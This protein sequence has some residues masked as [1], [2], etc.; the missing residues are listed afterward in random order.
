MPSPPSGQSGSP[1]SDSGG[2]PGQDGSRT[3]NDGSQPGDGSKGLP[4][5]GNGGQP[6]GNSS[7]AG[8]GD[9]QQDGDDWLEGGGGGGDDEWS[10]SNENLPTGS[11]SET[12]GASSTASRGPQ[13]DEP[14]GGGLD[15]ALDEALEGF[16]GTIMAEREVIKQGKAGNAPAGS[17]TPGDGPASSGNAQTAVNTEY[18]PPTR[19]APRSP[20]PGSG[21][22]TVPEDIPDA[23]DD[24]V[25]ARQVR[26]AAMKE[27]DPVLKEKLWEEYRRIKGKS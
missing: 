13:S 15:D 8:T 4:G 11:G 10:T 17:G 27:T 7:T 25:V 26:E 5:D 21:G 22:G 16:D 6:N 14:G 2:Q 12:T 1:Q 3:G 19:E 23:K 20:A 24:G 9:G 18:V